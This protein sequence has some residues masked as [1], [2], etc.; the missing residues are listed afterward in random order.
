[1]AQSETATTAGDS[2]VPNGYTDT[3]RACY[4]CQ[5]KVADAWAD[6]KY[7]S[8]NDGEL[9]SSDNF[10]GEQYADGSGVLH[11]YDT[12]E[13]IRTVDGT[14][15]SNAQCWSEG[16]AHCSTPSEIDARLP[17]Q[18]IEAH[19]D[20]SDDLLTSIKHIIGQ[21]ETRERTHSDDTYQSYTVEN[22]AVVFDGYTVIIGR[23]PSIK[24]GNS[25]FTFRVDHLR[26]ATKATADDVAQY[27]DDYLTPT[28]VEN[29]PMRVV[30]SDEY[31]KTRLDAD[32]RDAHVSHG[33]TLSE[34][35][36]S[37]RDEPVNYQHFRADL[38]GNVIV[39]HG[40][41]FFIPR[42]GVDLEATGEDYARDV[43][44]NHV[45]RREHGG[46]SPLPRV[47][48]CGSTRFD[49]ADDGTVTCRSCGY[50][51]VRNI[52]VRGEIAHANGDHDSINLGD[53]WYEAVSHDKDV[54]V[55]D[56]EPTKGNHS[57]RGRGRA[58]W[59]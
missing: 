59:D 22:T 53:T 10:R 54:R 29:S 50:N 42:T 2:G 6:M 48:D 5:Q 16:F 43:L 19:I 26:P 8:H 49:V 21:P 28:P 39:R 23:D 1:M 34:S 32:E 37:W 55:Y 25:R 47:C 46:V 18:A 11:H 36:S 45:P 40:E 41:W 38:Q 56:A 7:P 52:Y 17:L 58:R 27:I 4:D 33:G 14:V 35:R 20:D 24:E 44:D 13:A 51:D 15:I 30:S 9:Y 57:R 31:C 12:R 3:S